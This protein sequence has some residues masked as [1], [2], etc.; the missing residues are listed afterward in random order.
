MNPLCNEC[1]TK[2]KYNERYDSDY[3]ENCNMWL[4]KRCTDAECFYCRDRPENPSGS[5]SSAFHE[6]GL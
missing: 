2:L 4:D 5:A 6:K 1:Q 3:C